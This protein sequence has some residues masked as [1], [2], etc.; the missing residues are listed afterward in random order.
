MPKK[1]IGKSVWFPYKPKNN[2]DRSMKAR[3]LLQLPVNL[4]VHT[5]IIY[6]PKT[7]MTRA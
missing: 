1:G 3:Q 4:M 6:K 5:N 2:N 7:T